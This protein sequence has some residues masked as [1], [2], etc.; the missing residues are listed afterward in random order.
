[1]TDLLAADQATAAQKCASCPK[2]C[3]SACPTLAVTDNERH[4][5]WG[6]A[7]Q[8]VAAM[9]DG[10]AG[11]VD[12]ELVEGVYA[13]A[14]C[15]ACTPPCHVDGVETPLLTWAARAAVHRAGATPEVGVEA[16]RQ[17]AAGLVPSA[18]STQWTDPS[19]TLD[20]LRALASPGA[21]LLLF[22]GCGALGRR[23]G[24]VLAA[25]RALQALGIAFDVPAEHR[26]CG[27]VALTFGD[28]EASEAMRASVLAQ[29]AQ[30]RITVQS[31]SCSWLLARDADAEARGVEVEPLAA[32][33]AR[34]LR[35]RAPQH[36]NRRVAY[37]DPCYLAR[38]QHRRDEPRDALRSAGY[39][40][41][42]LRRHGDTTQ[43][44]GQGGGLPLTHPEIAR[45]YLQL[46]V[47]EVHVSGVDQVVTGCASCATALQGA[48]IQATELGEAVAAALE[49]EE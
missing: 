42:E 48:G 26:C 47:D 31:P 39:D 37:H 14:T 21:D 9:R 10:E 13:C 23:P 46:L 1:V 15:S 16:M 17:A 29:G 32:T 35:D 41:Q 33:L 44:S 2:M 25:G 43:C 6:H 19:A 8:I 27:M 5:P 7:R 20:A 3:R 40:V 11:F 38:H 30:R 12:P 49:V 34:A 24:A 18:E 28:T 4:Q 22:P 45:G 36:A